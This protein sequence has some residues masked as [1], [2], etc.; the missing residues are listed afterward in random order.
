MSGEL[1]AYDQV[2]ADAAQARKIKAI[3]DKAVELGLIITAN[4]QV[5]T[6]VVCPTDN[7]LVDIDCWKCGWMRDPTERKATVAK[8]RLVPSWTI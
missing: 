1:S 2:Q 7:E 8:A 4:G 5:T 6:D 3:R